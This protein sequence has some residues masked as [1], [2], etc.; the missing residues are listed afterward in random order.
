[1]EPWWFLRDRRGPQHLP[2]TCFT[3][4]GRFV[5]QHSGI[6]IFSFMPTALGP[7]MYTVL[8]AGRTLVGNPQYTA[9]MLDSDTKVKS[10]HVK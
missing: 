1:M 3:T 9:Y 4:R 5:T 7:K 10:M 6:G 8:S 2:D